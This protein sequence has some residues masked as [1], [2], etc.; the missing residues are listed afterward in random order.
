MNTRLLKFYSASLRCH[1]L[2]VLRAFVRRFV[3]VEQEGRRMQV[4]LIMCQAES[5]LDLSTRSYAISFITWLKI[6]SSKNFKVNRNPR[7]IIARGGNQ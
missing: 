3:I 5:R 1:R 4:Q 6:N 7:E 2:A